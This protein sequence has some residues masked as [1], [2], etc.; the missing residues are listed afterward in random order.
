MMSTIRTI[1][2]MTATAAIAPIIGPV[3]SE[4]SSPALVIVNRS[5][6]SLSPDNP[7]N[8][9]KIIFFTVKQFNKD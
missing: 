4:P 7:Y 2:R 5:V 1:S 8:I 3:A 9:S 6:T